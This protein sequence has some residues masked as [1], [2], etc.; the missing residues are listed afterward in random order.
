MRRHEKEIIW[1]VDGEIFLARLLEIK[2]APLG[3]IIRRLSPKQLAGLDRSE[4]N[5]VKSGGVV[6]VSLPQPGVSSRALLARIRESFPRHKVI[7]LT[8]M[9]QVGPAYP[10]EPSDQHSFPKPLNDLDGFI[11]LLTGLQ[12]KSGLLAGRPFEFQVVSP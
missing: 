2:L 10:E 8:P 9:G 7:N 6:I 11:K 12:E 3:L 5:P 4:L 1:L